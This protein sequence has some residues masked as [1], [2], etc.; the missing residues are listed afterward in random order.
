[1]KTLRDMNAITPLYTG[2][3]GYQ[4]SKRLDTL[5]DEDIVALNAMLP[6]HSYICDSLG[7]RFGV[8]SSP[9]KRN[10]ASM[11]PD[12][13]S[14]LLN[15]RYNLESLKVLEVGCFEGLHTS[16]L[17]MFGA[18]V[19][20]VDSRIEN[21]VKTLV[22]SNFLGFSPS[23]YQWDVETECKFEEVLWCSICHHVGVLYHLKDPVSHLQYLSQFIG[24][25][26]LLDTHIALPDQTTSELDCPWGPLKT[27]IFHE[28]GY[29]DP[30][31]GMGAVSH[32]LLLDDL[33]KILNKCGFRSV[34]IVEERPE[35][36]GPRVL[37]LAE[38]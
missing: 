34:E 7:R 31:S 2:E 19:V 14:L 4:K 37:L 28:S 12:Y 22:R 8:P 24:R 23:C 33:L 32:W 9:N 15:E 6:W 36:N 3:K 16:S 13:R 29:K 35:R 38:K 30:F 18:S 20:A 26:L 5:A 11:L 17:A 21:V 27:K 1:M 25:A 10:Q